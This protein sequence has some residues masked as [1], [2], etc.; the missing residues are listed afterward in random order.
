MLLVAFTNDWC[1]RIEFERDVVL[2]RLKVA[3]ELLISS[4]SLNSLT[5]YLRFAGHR[6]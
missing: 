1:R 6:H 4:T 2:R 3:N 5:N